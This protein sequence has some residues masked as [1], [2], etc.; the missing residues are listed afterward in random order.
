MKRL[1]LTLSIYCTFSISLIYSQLTPAE[2]GLEAITSD[3][4][5]AQLGFLSS[6]WTEGRMAGE[7]GEFLSADYIASI[8]QIY[9]VKPGGDRHQSRNVTN[10]D[11]TAERTYFQNF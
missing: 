2:K 9:G 1:L 3:A 7:R 4:I 11:N 5:K 10:G 6:N 8:L